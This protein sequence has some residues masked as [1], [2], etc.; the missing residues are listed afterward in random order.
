MRKGDKA[1]GIIGIWGL[2]VILMII[3][4]VFGGLG[5]IETAE[6]ATTVTVFYEG[7]EGAWPGDW[8]CLDEDSSSGEDYWGDS[9]H[10]AYAGSW[11]GYC[12]D[13]SDVS[14]QYYDNNMFA[15]MYQAVDL[16]GYDSATLSY[17][18]WL[19][20]ESN[21]DYLKVGY[22]DSV[23][24]SWHRPKSYCGNSGGWVY[25]SL[26]IPTT[27][28]WVGVLFDSDIGVTREG[29]Y[30]DEIY[31]TAEEGSQPPTVAPTHISPSNGATDISLTPTF[32]WGSVANA[33]YY[34]L[35]ISEPPYGAAHLV[36]DSE[37]DYGNIYGTSF[38]LADAGI[39]LDQGVTYHW[40]MRAWNEGGHGP[41]SSDWSFTTTG[42]EPPSLEGIDVSHYQGDIDWSQ[43]YNAGYRFA[44][45]KAT[46]GD[47]RPPQIIDDHFETNM[48]EGHDAGMLMGAYHFAHP[49]VNDATDEAQFFVNVADDYLTEGYLRP[50]LDLESGASLGKTALSTWVHEWMN[51]VKSETGIEP[52]IYVNSNYANNYLDSSVSSYEL[53]IA[54]WTYDPD[55]SPNTGIWNDWDFW[56]YSDAGS[57]PGVNGDVDMDLFN[58]DMSRLNTF[59]IAQPSQP[60]TAD[61]GGPY[62]G[63]IN[64]LV[65]FHGSAT[66]G[67]PPYTYAWDFDNNGVID[68][69]LQNPTHSWSVAGTYYPTLKVVDDKGRYS[70]LDE[71][72]VLIK[73]PPSYGGDLTGVHSYP[74]Y[75]IGENVDIDV[76]IKNTGNTV[77]TYDLHLVVHDKHDTPVYDDT[78]DSIYLSAGAEKSEKFSAT[79]LPVGHYSFIAS[80]SSSSS[81]KVY[82]DAYGGF[83]VLDPQAIQLVEDDAES[84]K[85]ATFNELDEMTTIVSDTASTT[86]T[87]VGW[88]LISGAIRG[89]IVGL[90][91]TDTFTID[92]NP[93][94]GV[95]EQDI[96]DASLRATGA[97]DLFGYALPKFEFEEKIKSWYTA[98]EVGKIED[99][100][101]SF[102]NF[103]QDKAFTRNDEL[104]QIFNTGKTAVR[105]IVESKPW[106]TIG[107]Y[108][109]N[110][111]L[112]G[113]EVSYD[114]TLKEEED[115][116]KDVKKYSFLFSIIVVVL[117]VI[118]TVIAVIGTGGATLLL[119]PGIL[120]KIK[121]ILCG[122]KLL[123]EMGL[124]VVTIM[125][126]LTLPHIAPMVTD[127]HNTT[128]NSIQD[129]ILTQ[130]TTSTTNVLSIATPPQTSFGKDTKFLITVDKG[131]SKTPEPIIGIVVSPDGRVIDLSL[132]KTNPYS[133]YETLSSSIRLP[134]QPGKYKILAMTYGDMM[135]SSVKQ[136]ETTQTAPNISVSISTDKSFYN[137]TET[138]TINA[139]FTNT[140]PEK[141][142]N[143]MFSIDVLNTTYN[144]TGFLEIDASSTKMET[145]SFVP[146]TNGTCKATVALFAGLYIVDFAETGFTVES[147]KGVSVNVDSKEVYDPNTNVTANFT[148]K[149]IGTELYQ[150]DIVVTT[151]DTL[152]DYLEVYNSIELLSINESEEKELLCVI[153]PKE[154]ST[155]SIYRTYI[156]VDNSTYIVP[157]TVAANGTLF[158]TVQTA[159]LIYL[160]SES[161]T[162]N[163]SVK[164]VAFNATNTTLNLTLTDPN[165][166]KTYSDVTGSN[167]NY[168]T[169]ISPDKKSENGTYH[170]LVNGSKEGYRVYSDKTFFI[171][172]ERTK[173]RCDIPRLIQLNTTDTIN[174][175]VETDTNQSVKDVFVSLTG[176]G[177][178]GT[179]TTDE[180]GL[181][182]F[183]TGS[184][185]ETGI[186]EVSIEKGGYCSF[187]GTIEAVGNEEENIFDTGS[188]AN[189]YP[190]ITG[191]HNG[192][193]KPNQTI[194]VQKL[195]TYPCEGTGGHTE[196]AEIRNATWNATATWEGYVGD[197]HNVTFDKTVVL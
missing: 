140:A 126:L 169:I 139:N 21:Y 13:E 31:L 134:H 7:F 123:S 49:E 128:L 131:V 27:A 187:I 133:N 181:A 53:W 98:P 84:L 45:A 70:K 118:I 10:R 75:S 22:Y 77:E 156:S 44:F 37:D 106:F 110:G 47:H 2:I 189:P 11:S 33:D 155:P 28:S 74:H 81:G 29:A 109:L 105:N 188:P 82:D 151:V 168:T 129:L 196:Y 160:A 97:I 127:Q 89:Q 111:F 95:T 46:E 20:S 190:S 117:S 35:F 88:S 61:A 23:D 113:G 101:T 19:D 159:K 15:K 64:E 120:V 185:N 164:D 96:I 69:P 157:F 94:P 135:K 143:L 91:S 39:S 30:V 66:D 182:I 25:D 103:V 130:Q 141:V 52:I 193:I 59:V 9:N 57:V 41:I 17:Y 116:Y 99:N 174:L 48:N 56:Q 83:R 137:F 104:I 175:F 24:N 79:S 148:I 177:F 3:G 78:I 178:N 72:T 145:L 36:F 184:M 149:N 195:Y 179:R 34:A 125:M 152:N 102:D 18:Y 115:I 93:I 191:M 124:V 136:V 26:S 1:R 167:G 176:C 166:N 153:L 63:N 73:N 100:D 68:S 76:D 154:S 67:T 142:G 62:Y 171:V 173:L 197:W 146:Q 183:G 147:G 87:D 65:Q 132:Y 80:L 54:H 172:N 43:V 165:G 119:L 14:G 121:G 114:V 12:A 150:G 71:C 4:S 55:A 163:I 122:F 86:V 16:S 8:H 40:D 161:V 186:I 58:G 138:V 51:T 60:P 107:P 50:V 194:T 192:T 32:Q 92:G 38:N 5:G 90:Y 162:V 85:Q 144:K 158:I 42:P 180:N 112:P 170:I 108:D 6:G